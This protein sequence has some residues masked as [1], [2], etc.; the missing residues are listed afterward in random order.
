MVVGAGLLTG[1]Q[2][3]GRRVARWAGRGRTRSRPA[4]TDRPTCGDAASL[5]DLHLRCQCEPMRCHLMWQQYRQWT[6]TLSGLA[7]GALVTGGE[8]R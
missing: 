6:A 5:P 7:S 8:E 3:A 1:V 4:K 2:A